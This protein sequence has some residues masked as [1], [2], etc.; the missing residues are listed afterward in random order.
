MSG[1]LGHLVVTSDADSDR[2]LVSH[3]G[4][5]RVVIAARAAYRCSARAAVVLAE[6][7]YLS[8]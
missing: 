1:V 7:D 6:T 3:W 2:Q 5:D 4:V 8:N